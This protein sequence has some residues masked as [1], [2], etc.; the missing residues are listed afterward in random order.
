MNP[1]ALA[2]IFHHHQIPPLNQKTTYLDKLDTSL[3]V[4]RGCQNNLRKQAILSCSSIYTIV[5]TDPKLASLN[6][7]AAEGI[8]WHQRAV[9]DIKRL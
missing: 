4:K 6:Q 9:K 8:T 7:K 3:L 2:D 1:A 5:A